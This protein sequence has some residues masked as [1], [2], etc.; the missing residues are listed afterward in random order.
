MMKKDIIVNT[1]KN[2]NGILK[3]SDLRDKDISGSY[4]FEYIKENGFIRVSKGIYLSPEFWE[5]PIYLIQLRYR[6]IVFSHETA[7][8]LLD[9]AE[10]EPLRYSVTAKAH[11]NV[12][13]LYK[14]GIQVHTVKKE[15][16]GL[17]ITEKKTPMNNTVKCYNAERT[18]CDI[19]RNRN[20]TDKQDL[21]AAMKNYVGQTRKNIPQ[22]MRYAREFRVEKVIRQYMEVL[23]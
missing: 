3:V 23:L 19:V 8:Y 5:D 15:L 14:R 18:L 12:K 13:S 6:E 20:D 4:L 9:L 16:F 10:R 22:L 1:V 2:N 11:Y 7:L 17:G 21:N